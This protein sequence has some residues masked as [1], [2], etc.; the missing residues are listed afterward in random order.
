MHAPAWPQYSL[1]A[2]VHVGHD[3]RHLGALGDLDGLGDRFLQMPAVVPYVGVVGPAVRRERLRHLDDL[4][5]V[6]EDGVLVHQP[7]AEAPRAVRQGAGH[8]VAHLGA[9]VGTCRAVGLSHHDV[10]DVQVP[11]QR[12]DVDR[13]PG[14]PH[15]VE[16]L[17]HPSPR[18]SRSRRTS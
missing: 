3:Q 14:L 17:A 10:P 8:E 11:G 2:G 1:P 7:G 15:G 5:R 6:G 18:S 16:I 13:R 12:H 9:L 4:V